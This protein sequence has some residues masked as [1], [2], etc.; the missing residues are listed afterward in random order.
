MEQIDRWCERHGLTK[1]AVVPID[2]IWEL[3]RTWYGRHLAP[4][5]QKWTP[6]EA[7]EILERVGLRGEHWRLDTESDR[8]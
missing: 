7:Q 8:F 3:A 4:D 1:G 2:V 5:W 6:L